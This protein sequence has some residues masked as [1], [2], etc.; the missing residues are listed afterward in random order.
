[1]KFIKTHPSLIG[2]VDRI[3]RHVIPP[4]LHLSQ[5]HE[6]SNSDVWR[7]Q[8]KIANKE[9]RTRQDWTHQQE[10]GPELVTL[11]QSVRLDTT[12]R[13]M[14]CVSCRVVLRI[15]PSGIW[16]LPSNSDV[17]LVGPGGD[18]CQRL[19]C[20]CVCVCVCGK[21]KVGLQQLQ[22][23]QTQA[24]SIQCIDTVHATGT[25]EEI[26]GRRLRSHAAFGFA[27]RRRRRRRYITVGWR[28]R[29]R[30]RA[31]INNKTDNL[32]FQ[33]DAGRH[34]LPVLSRGIATDWR[35]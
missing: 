27:L 6:P 1:M 33:P 16:A 34:R 7:R 10:Y 29:Y 30:R 18:G 12:R 22:Q 20:V 28:Q 31:S 35:W 26:D 2:P 9:H 8:K 24:V 11:R 15:K 5:L 23:Q 21:W 32:R 3:A 14:S 25:S 13:D 17:V 19:L 4:D